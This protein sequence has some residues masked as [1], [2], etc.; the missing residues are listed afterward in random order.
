MVMRVCGSRSVKQQGAAADFA[1]GMRSHHEQVR[2]QA[3]SRKLD[4]AIPCKMPSL[5]QQPPCANAP[6]SS[7]STSVSKNLYLS[8]CCAFC[9]PLEMVGI[10]KKKPSLLQRNQWEHSGGSRTLPAHCLPGWATL[11]AALPSLC[12]AAP[13]LSFLITCVLRKAES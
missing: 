3:G 11:C 6:V 13:N 5:C 8:H 7:S 9:D 4:C 10:V 1:W 12:P 2:H